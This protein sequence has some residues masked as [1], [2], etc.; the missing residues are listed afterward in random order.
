MPTLGAL[1]KSFNKGTSESEVHS[2]RISQALFNSNA[3]SGSG[4]HTAGSASTRSRRFVGMPL[5][6]KQSR[7]HP[8]DLS[9]TPKDL[10]SKA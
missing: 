5:R 7:N 8:F 1:D 10:D 6:R 3:P 4:R 9:F 2:C